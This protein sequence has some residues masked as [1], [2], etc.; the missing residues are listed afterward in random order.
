M[1]HI[2]M[3][4]AKQSWEEQRT[5]ALATVGA[6]AEAGHREVQ[7]ERVMVRRSRGACGC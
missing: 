7:R 4:S 1:W 3:F 5:V 2:P 6:E